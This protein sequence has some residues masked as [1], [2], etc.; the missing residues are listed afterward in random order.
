MKQGTGNREQ[1]TEDLKQ[2]LRA[3]VPPIEENTEQERDL[4]PMMQARLHQP[5]AVIGL[6][7][8]PW[9]DWAL[10]GGVALFSVAFP[11]SIPV[12]LYYL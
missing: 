12:L 8:V 5:D 9:F 11:A 6:R 3:G 10:V 4:W 7:S 1:G 2:L